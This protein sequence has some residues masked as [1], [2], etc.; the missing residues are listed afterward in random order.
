[1]KYAFVWTYKD[2]VTKLLYI[3]KTFHK[4]AEYLY[5]KFEKYVW[6]KILIIIK[7]KTLQKS[8]KRFI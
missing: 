4:L 7:N 3:L 8:Q 5:R 2:A 1:M 6:C